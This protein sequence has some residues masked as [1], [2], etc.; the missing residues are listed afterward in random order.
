M[1]LPPT[2]EQ[3]RD[4]ATT[5]DALSNLALGITKP[6]SNIEIV[7]EG[8]PATEEWLAQFREWVVGTEMQDDLRAWADEL[9][10]KT[11]FGKDD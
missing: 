9:E 5:L 11:E 8:E 1:T 4:I 7:I 10:L 3:L 6:G 2:P